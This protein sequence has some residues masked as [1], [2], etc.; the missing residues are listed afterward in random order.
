MQNQSTKIGSLLSLLIFEANS[1][2][3]ILPARI[4]GHILNY[5]PRSPETKIWREDPN[6]LGYST[7]LH[8]LL[9]SAD[10]PIVYYK[11]V[12]VSSGLMFGSPP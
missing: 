8:A 11:S 6:S 7:E 2:D 1:F 9:Y 4:A 3:E 5:L 12:V 10:Q